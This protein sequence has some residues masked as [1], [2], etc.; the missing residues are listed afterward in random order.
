MAPGCDLGRI[1]TTENFGN[2]KSTKICWTGVD[3][4][5][6]LL[7]LKGVAEGR[8][9]VREH[10][11]Q[12][13]ND[14]VDDHGGRKF[15][16][17]EYVISNADLMGDKVGT[18][19]LIDAFVVAGEEKKVA[20]KR[21]VVG[22]WLVEGR[23]IWGHVD[24]GIVVD[25]LLKLFDAGNDRLDAQDHAC[26]STIGRVVDLAMGTKPMVAQVMEVEL[27]HSFLDGPGD[28]GVGKGALKQFGVG[29][30]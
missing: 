5:G 25:F 14:G 20:L 29:G 9:W 18:N 10:A 7:V 3:R 22:H 21:E 11:R 26:P 1:S 12:E 8:S 17:G 4:G 13:T 19:T 28:D 23:P 15:S 6:K 27:D 30:E 2:F 16:A 24:K